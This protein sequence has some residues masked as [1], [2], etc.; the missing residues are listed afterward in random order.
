MGQYQA[1]EKTTL[2]WDAGVAYSREDLRQKTPTAGFVFDTDENQD[3]SS[4]NIQLGAHHQ[5]SPGSHFFGVVNLASLNQ[6]TESVALPGRTQEF[7]IAFDR[8]IDPFDV[9][10]FTFSDEDYTRDAYFLET[11]FQY[12]L[13]SELVTSVIGARA[14]FSF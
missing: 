4:V 8:E 1:S 14:H 12:M 9:D 5:F 13:Q 6:S 11:D 7:S 3:I 10:V 2:I